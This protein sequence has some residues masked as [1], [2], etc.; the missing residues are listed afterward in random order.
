MTFAF[1]HAVVKGSDM[2]SNANLCDSLTTLTALDSP[3]TELNHARIRANCPICPAGTSSTKFWKQPSFHQCS[4]CGLIFR[5]PFP[6]AATLS[7]LYTSSWASPDENKRETGATELINAQSLVRFLT[8]SIGN[9]GLSGKRILDFGAG[10]G[11][12]AMALREKGAQVMAVEPFGFDSLTRLGVPTYR[13][14]E[15]LPRDARFEGI[16]SLEVFEHLPEPRRTLQHLHRHLAPG[17]WLFI[18]TP[19]AGGLLA[20][21]QGEHWREAVRPGHVVFFTPPTLKSLL[22][23]TGFCRV[24]RPRGLVRYTGKMQLRT[25]LN[26]AMQVALVDGGLRILAFKH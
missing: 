10:R 7:R 23:E 4:R 18:T 22:A 11:A 2:N 16:V 17:G 26:F 20:R 12:M 13:D 5:N 8:R 1:K 19:N 6:D 21:L 25:I 24:K 15:E 14:L 3:E 9:E